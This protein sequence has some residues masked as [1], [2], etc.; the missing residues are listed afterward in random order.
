MTTVTLTRKQLIIV[1]VVGAL[2]CIL[3]IVLGVLW[4]LRPSTQPPAPQPLDD[5]DAPTV[6]M[7][8]VDG[9]GDGDGDGDPDSL[10]EFHHR[11]SAPQVYASAGIEPRSVD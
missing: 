7:D 4:Y 2:V 5:G 10:S 1:A 3:A 6:R 9:V 8:H 11:T